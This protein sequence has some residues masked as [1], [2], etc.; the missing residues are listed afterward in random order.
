MRRSASSTRCSTRAPRDRSVPPVTAELPTVDAPLRAGAH[1]LY[2]HRGAPVVRY[3][4]DVRPDEI[5]TIVTRMS[6]GVVALAA[7]VVDV[8]EMGSFGAKTRKALAANLEFDP[9]LLPHQMVVIISGASV[10]KRAIMTMA[11]TAARMISG[12]TQGIRLQFTKTLGEA[13][14][15]LDGVIDERT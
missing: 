11:T 8:S 14:E 12:M 9:S 4:G 7:A 10:T 3:N 5:T 15:L 6:D 13:I 1:R 2:F